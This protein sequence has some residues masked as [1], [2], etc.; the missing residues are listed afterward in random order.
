MNSI[1]IQITYKWGVM[2]SYQ[3]FYKND[4]FNNKLFNFFLMNYPVRVVLPQYETRKQKFYEE[5][6]KQRLAG[7]K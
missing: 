1:Q 6:E 5:R 3:P 2:F 4:S 7:G